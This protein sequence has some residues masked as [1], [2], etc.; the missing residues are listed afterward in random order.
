MSDSAQSA[1]WDKY[2]DTRLLERNRLVRPHHRKAMFVFID[3]FSTQ[4]LDLEILDVGCGGGLFLEILRDLGFTRLTGI[5]L[6]ASHVERAQQK[7]LPVHKADAM[8]YAPE[9]APDR[10]ILMDILEH[11]PDPG[12][13][14]ARVRQWLAPGGLIYVQIPIYESLH[15]RLDRIVSGKTMIQQAQ[16]QDETHIQAFTRASFLK[17]LYDQSLTP[18]LVKS[19]WG[20]IPYLKRPIAVTE[21]FAEKTG[22]FCDHI[23]AVVKRLKGS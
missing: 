14:L 17:L 4:P 11:S 5:D 10:V 8:T 21:W 2:S 13:I 9:K 22:L 20:A 15:R 12:E 1:D 18:V 3:F 19:W 23:V 16:E 6:A 7:G